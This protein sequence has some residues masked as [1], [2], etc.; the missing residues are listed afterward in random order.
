MFLL[1]CANKKNIL[2]L[3]DI[4]E[5][6]KDDN[7]SKNV[8][9]F[10]KDDEIMINVSSSDK[11][12]AVPFNLPLVSRSNNNQITNQATIQS[13]LVNKDGSIQ[14]PIIGKIY[15]L[16]K[17]KEELRTE[18]VNKIEKFVKS[19][20]INIRINNFK[21]SVLGEVR[22]PGIYP[23]QNERV[24]I[25]DALSM[26]G[27]LSI[28]G[29]RK[30][31]LVIR[32][33]NDYEKEYYKIDLTSTDIFNSEAYYLQQND[34]VLVNPNKAQVQASAFNRNTPIYVSIASLLISV[35]IT[36]SRL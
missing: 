3:Q 31:V 5:Y 22:K 30:E 16:N 14:F 27:D 4:E 24:S 9:R 13:Y 26:A 29:K 17:T 7:N 15:V 36:I 1:S 6:Q 32:E 10:K 28:Y 33:N 25:I 23:V 35:L 21:I 20:I 34:V 8:I 11:T 19:P 12:S 2:Y 18:L